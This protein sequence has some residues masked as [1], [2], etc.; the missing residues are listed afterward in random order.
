[1]VDSTSSDGERQEAEKDPPRIAYRLAHEAAVECTRSVYVM[2]EAYRNRAVG[3]L[4]VSAIV[5][6]AG[7]GF[8]TGETESRGCLTWFGVFVAVLGFLASLLATSMLLRPFKGAFEI[9]PKTLVENYGD[10]PAKYPTDDDT[11]RK[12]ALYGET[13]SSKLSQEVAQR[14]KWI[15]AS[16]A[17]LVAASAG[18]ALVWFDAF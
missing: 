5:I 3:M 16:M 9:S 10:N 17:G 12:L 8:V 14:C 1:M 13:E 11:Y 2:L 18:A 7:F 6:V 15:Y 4:S